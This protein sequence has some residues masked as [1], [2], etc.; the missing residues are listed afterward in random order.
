MKLKINHNLLF[1][2]LLV[3]GSVLADDRPAPASGAWVNGAA[4]QRA[5]SGQFHI[6]N[7]ADQITGPIN[8]GATYTGNYVSP[9]LDTPPGFGFSSLYMATDDFTHNPLFNPIKFR[10]SVTLS[11]TEFENINIDPRTFLPSTLHGIRQELTI[12]N[13]CGP[14]ETRGDL[15]EIADITDW[16]RCY[17]D[18]RTNAQNPNYSDQTLLYE[19]QRI[20]ECLRT[21][22]F[23]PVATIMR[24]NAE[25]NRTYRH[26]SSTFNQQMSEHWNKPESPLN[27]TMNNV[28]DGL[29]FQ[30]L[31]VLKDRDLMSAY[32]ANLFV[33]NPNGPNVQFKE[34]GSISLNLKR[35]PEARL[36][37]ADEPYA[38]G[39]CLSPRD[40]IAMRQFPRGEDL[41]FIQADLNAP[42]DPNAFNFN[43]LEEDYQEM[44]K[45]PVAERGQPENRLKIKQLKAKLKFLNRNPLIK[46]LM[47]SEAVGV[48]ENS[49]N[50]VEGAM[51]RVI[52]GINNISYL[53][54]KSR[55]FN[56]MKILAR[57]DCVRDSEC[58]NEY[59]TQLKNFFKREEAMLM[60]KVEAQKDIEKK[61]KRQ[62]D[63]TNYFESTGAR[64]PVTR[65]SVLDEF[66]AQYNLPAPST[67]DPDINGDDAEKCLDIYA[68][69]CRTLDRVAPNPAEAS[70]V[71][72]EIADTLEE[73][74]KDDFNPDYATNEAFQEA[75][76]RFCNTKRG[77][78]FRRDF[79]IN[80]YVQN[81][82]RKQSNA[83]HCPPRTERDWS[84][85]RTKYDG[86]RE[87]DDA[88]DRMLAGVDGEN[89][90]GGS[91]LMGR[92]D[93]NAAIVP[94][95]GN[96]FR[97]FDRYAERER[98]FESE[99]VSVRNRSNEE[100]DY[101]QA[102]TSSTS[103]RSFVREDSQPDNFV[104]YSTIDSSQT[105]V[106]N[107][108]QLNSS[109]ED[110]RVQ[111]MDQTRRQ[112]M[113]EDWEREYGIWKDRYGSDKSPATAAQDSQYRTEIS[114]LRALLDQQRQISDQQYQLLNDAIAARN[115][116]EQ[117]N[118]AQNEERIRQ[119]DRS[120]N[121]QN[122]DAS[123]I[124]GNTDDGLPVRSPASVTEQVLSSSGASGGGQN[125]GGS[126]SVG[127]ASGGGRSSASIGPSGS[128]D[129]VAREE[130]K[131]VNLRQSS[132]GSIIIVPSGN[133]S[134]VSPNAITVPV[135]DEQYRILQTNPRGLNLS[136]IERS[137]PQDQ[138]ARLE[139][140]GEIILLLQ[141]GDNPPFEVKVEKKDNRLVYRLRDSSGREQSPIRRVFTR[142]ALLNNLVQ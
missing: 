98:I 37:T 35:E 139:Q 118:I 124:S 11:T 47:G 41:T 1:I 46:Y 12:D 13:S 14:S 57:P 33:E 97:P 135:S 59:Q 123:F 36:V 38:P 108:S 131:L 110:Q 132:D 70:P 48:A 58:K 76:D 5:A 122:S 119:R 115:R 66:L 27:E 68:G 9:R 83:Q 82:C 109:T 16:T 64:P 54:E 6:A 86:T 40:F 21:S 94:T 32:S 23:E 18:R 39:Q 136:Q 84:Y 128:S 2:L 103:S 77:G 112:E 28:L 8:L 133:G 121:S 127:G 31:N 138:I 90:K 117:E 69:Y 30:S 65:R 24:D 87:I 129:S 80:E 111:D 88:H 60:T 63:Q 107:N 25:I 67:C 55:L 50:L 74:L 4:I 140:N 92:D 3:S 29:M 126:A 137:I 73:D 81:E 26:I 78:A 99:T 116:L 134:G 113:L 22:R 10:S 17:T 101:S 125:T 105:V 106:S 62:I 45:K 42:F 114:T 53:S 34:D 44:M 7:P 72:R 56:I 141:N 51:N 130:A 104:N 120:R 20:C 85:F 89:G 71:D 142:N 43:K 19:D 100:P 15:S 91:E 49:S 102:T 79:S 95:N 75:N 61:V 96:P 93:F 52:D